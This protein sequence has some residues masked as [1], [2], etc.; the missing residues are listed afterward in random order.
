MSKIQNDNGCV[1]PKIKNIQG[2]TGCSISVVS[3]LTNWLSDEL[4]NNFSLEDLM[5][6]SI[7]EIYIQ[8]IL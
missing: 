2:Y 3:V 7:A 8:K 1:S 5:D 4:K 6:D